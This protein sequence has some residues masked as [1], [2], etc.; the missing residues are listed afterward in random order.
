MRLY[1]H[2]CNNTALLTLKWQSIASLF[3][4]IMHVTHSTEMVNAYKISAENL[5]D[6]LEHFAIYKRTSK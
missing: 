1:N 5:K 6:H 3:R 2:V 4:I